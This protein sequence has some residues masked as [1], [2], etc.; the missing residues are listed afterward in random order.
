MTSLKRIKIDDLV[1]VSLVGIDRFFTR[2]NLSI[3]GAREGDDSVDNT[4]A[5]QNISVND[6]ENTWGDPDLYP[7]LTAL[8]FGAHQI[9][10]VRAAWKKLGLDE[11]ALPEALD[12]AEW[13]AAHASEC[14]RDIERPLNYIFKSLKN[15]MLSPPP[16]YRSRR[17]IVADAM[18]QRAEE[19]R[20]LEQQYFEDAFTVW[21]HELSEAER[22]KIDGANKV[23]ALHET[24]RREY[25]RQ[26]VYQPLA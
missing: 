6:P 11:E 14:L 20:R 7:H 3:L 26:H 8:G 24:H 15:G 2:E 5:G 17:Q 4:T 22:K 12:R 21:W 18:H 25:F 13:M 23:G 10:Q 16:G 19:I 1:A 9:Q